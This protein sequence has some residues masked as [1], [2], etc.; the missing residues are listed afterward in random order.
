MGT[1][2]HK[3]WDETVAGPAPETGLGK[4][5]KQKDQISAVRSPPQISGDHAVTRSIT[6]VKGNN[7]GILRN[8]RIDSGRLPDSPVGSS[9]NPG[10][11]HTP[12]TPGEVDAQTLTTYDW[13]VINALD[14]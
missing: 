9:S 4:L 2:L 14:R 8:L 7:G 5:K 10:T 11:P 1:L 3:L 13:I 12:G 6:V